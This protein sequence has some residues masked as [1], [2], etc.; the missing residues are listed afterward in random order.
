VAGSQR[1]IEQFG[2]VWCS[3]VDDL[4][5]NRRRHWISG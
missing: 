5:Q 3:Q 4:L 2:E 1:A